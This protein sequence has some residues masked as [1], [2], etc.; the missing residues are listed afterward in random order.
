MA[1]LLQLEFWG[2]LGSR[3]QS[4]AAVVGICVALEAGAVYYQ[5]ALMYFP[6][7]LCIYTRVWIAAIALVA[8]LGLVVRKQVWLMRAVLVAQIGLCLGLAGVVWKLIAIDYEFASDGACSL[9]PNF[10]SWA[11]LD[12]WF[13]MLFSVQASCGKTPEIVFGLSMADGLAGVTLGFLVAFTLALVGSFVTADR[14]GEALA[15]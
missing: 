10:P 7:E 11:P 3:W 5:E 6:C 12:Q 2:S 15:A 9:Y 4:W 1:R 13:P 8:L 14:R